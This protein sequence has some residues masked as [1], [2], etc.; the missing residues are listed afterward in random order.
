MRQTLPYIALIL[1]V[2]TLGVMSSSAVR[3][4]RPYSVEVDGLTFVD[5]LAC[6][7]DDNCMDITAFGDDPTEGGCDTDLDCCLQRPDADPKFCFGE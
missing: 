2:Y 4:S 7:L 3:F 6:R 1:V 5:I